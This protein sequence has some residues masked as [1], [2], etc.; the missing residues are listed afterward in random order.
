MAAFDFNPKQRMITGTKA[1]LAR[2]ARFLITDEGSASLIFKSG[3]DVT[4][5]RDVKLSTTAEELTAEIKR[6]E[7]RSGKRFRGW[8]SRFQPRNFGTRIFLVFS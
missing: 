6:E 8:N 3:R 7:R 1:G 2:L 5:S 4:G